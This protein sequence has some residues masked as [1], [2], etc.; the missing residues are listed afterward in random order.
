M[1]R[2]AR[3]PAAL[4]FLAGSRTRSCPSATR[5]RTSAISSG[6]AWIGSVVADSAAG[7]DRFTA[8]AQAS[9]EARH[10]SLA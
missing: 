3:I 9:P 4:G 7:A 8:T 10:A 1:R 2:S 6:E 5:R